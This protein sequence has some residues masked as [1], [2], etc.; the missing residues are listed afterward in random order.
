MDGC[1]GLTA[2]HS[3]DEHHSVWLTL[4]HK[5]MRRTKADKRMTC[6]TVHWVTGKITVSPGPQ[7]LGQHFEP[8]PQ[9]PHCPLPYPTSDPMLRAICR[10]APC[11]RPHDLIKCNYHQSLVLRGRRGVNG[12]ETSCFRETN[13]FC[14]YASHNINNNNNK[15]WKKQCFGESKEKVSISIITAS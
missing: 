11:R 10:S 5:Q 8:W 4:P 12:G 3:T 14:I 1:D 9:M 6:F 15:V 2:S 13:R 7:T